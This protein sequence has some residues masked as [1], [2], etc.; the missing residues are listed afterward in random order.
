VLG[1]DIGVV[2]G[3]GLLGG[4]RQHLLDPGRVRDVAARF[5][6]AAAPDLLLD[7]LADGIEV[8]PH[9]LQ[10]IDGN[11]LPQLDEPQQQV[12]GADEIVVEAIGLLARQGKDLLG[13][14]GEVVEGFFAH[15]LKD[16]GAIRTNRTQSGHQSPIR[17]KSLKPAGIPAT[18]D[19]GDFGRALKPWDG[20]PRTR[21]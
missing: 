17:Q 21:P 18:G 6:L 14:W 19:I 15:D 11:P 3:L 2:Q 12:L 4:Q 16:A 9:L 1:A 20:S 10:H 5:G 13:A 8:E 7:L